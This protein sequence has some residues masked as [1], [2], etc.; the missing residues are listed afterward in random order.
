MITVINAFEDRVREVDNYLKWLKELEAP[1]TIL[2]REAKHTHNRLRLDADFIKMLKASFLLVLYNLVEAGISSAIERL[3]TI[4]NANNC[5]YS[6]IR[7]EL[8]DLWVSCCCK[9]ALDPNASW[10][11]YTRVA[12]YM[13]N[14][15]IDN[16]TLKLERKRVMGGGNLNAD[17]I[18]RICT[19]HGIS[20]KAHYRAKG[21][22]SLEIVMVKRNSLAHGTESFTECGRNFAVADL[23]RLNRECAIYIRSILGNMRSYCDSSK[24]NA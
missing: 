4:M 3:Y 15:A 2:V 17:R 13:V 7:R 14:T 5:T 20:H 11:T 10:N 19:D 23:A 1:D 9:K 16:A 12:R 18:R 24:Y 21:G 22:I 8:R 6:S